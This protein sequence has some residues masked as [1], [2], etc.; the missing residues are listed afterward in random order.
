[1]NLDINNKFYLFN[2]G[3]MYIMITIY[4]NN[5]IK[6]EIDALK[7]LSLRNDIIITKQGRRSVLMNGTVEIKRAGGL[8]GVL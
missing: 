4:I 7:D 5:L 6:N 8:G 2:D 3:N 1:M